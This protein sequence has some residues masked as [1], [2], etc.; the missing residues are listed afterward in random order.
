M[1]AGAGSHFRETPLRE[2]RSVNDGTSRL[3]ENG[4][5]GFT[6][7][8]SA[9]KRDDHSADRTLTSLDIRRGSNPRKRTFTFEHK[10]IATE[11]NR[12]Y[13][14]RVIFLFRRSDTVGAEIVSNG[15]SFSEHC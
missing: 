9:K 15:T 12:H 8:A 13:R 4:D 10:S 2:T 3:A 7:T 1:F 11:N 5:R 6:I 14:I